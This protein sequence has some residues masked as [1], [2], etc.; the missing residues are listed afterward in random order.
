MPLFLLASATE[1]SPAARSGGSSTPNWR[2]VA[3]NLAAGATAG[4]AVEAGEEP[5]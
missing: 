2:V 3:G 5:H 4:C 1:V